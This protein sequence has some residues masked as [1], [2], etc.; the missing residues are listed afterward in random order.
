MKLGTI[1][2]LP[3]AASL[4][5]VPTMAGAVG[6]LS[7]EAPFVCVP[8][9]VWECSSNGDCLRGTARSE[10]LPNFFTIDLKAKTLH[11]EEKG[12]ESS[13]ERVHSIG[14]RTILYGQDGISPWVVMINFKTGILTANV[15][16]DEESFVIDGVC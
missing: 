5:L 14:D 4:A 2:A 15:T 10:N 7:S 1:I 3:F 16:G 12:R 11:A 8:T 9:A 13:I 6:T